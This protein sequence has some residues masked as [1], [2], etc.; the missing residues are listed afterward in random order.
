MKSTKYKLRIYVN[1][2]IYTYIDM[3]LNK[4]LLNN[5]C[6]LR[7]NIGREIEIG[8]NKLFRDM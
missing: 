7:K 3:Y 8:M 1:I 2:Y 6:A 5:K 4:Y